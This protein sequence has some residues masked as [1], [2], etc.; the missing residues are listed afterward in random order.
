MMLF[1]ASLLKKPK[2]RSPGRGR[3]SRLRIPTGTPRI[4]ESSSAR[5]ERTSRLAWETLIDEISRSASARL[6]LLKGRQGSDRV[7]CPWERLTPCDG[8]CRCG[9]G[10]TVTVAFLRA[11][12]THLAIEVALFARPSSLQRKS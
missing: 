3:R 10:R 8:D 12:Y 5:I 9:G 2:S 4:V 7:A 1:S 11:H 6:A